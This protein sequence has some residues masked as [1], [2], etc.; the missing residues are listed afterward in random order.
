MVIVGFYS[1]CMY[2]YE[3]IGFAS[4]ESRNFLYLFAFE[5]PFTKVKIIIYSS[6]PF[7]KISGHESQLLTQCCRVTDFSN[8]LLLFSLSLLS[9]QDNYFLLNFTCKLGEALEIR[10]IPWRLLL[11][12]C[13]FHIYIYTHNSPFSIIS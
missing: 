11:S 5:E 8:N 1:L 10:G 6:K 7:V 12:F 9:K 4:D 3:W 13:P 2:V